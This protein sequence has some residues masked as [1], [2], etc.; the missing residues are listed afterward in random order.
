MSFPNK[1]SHGLQARIA[2][3]RSPTTDHS[4]IVFTSSLEI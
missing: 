1:R 2:Q 3:V 4:I